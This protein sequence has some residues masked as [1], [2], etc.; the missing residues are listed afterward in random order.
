[1]AAK[2]AQNAMRRDLHQ[3]QPLE[4]L[5]VRRLRYSDGPTTIPWSVFVSLIGIPFQERCWYENPIAFLKN[6]KS[7]VSLIW[8]R[9][10]QK[11]WNSEHGSPRHVHDRGA[12][13]FRCK[14]RFGQR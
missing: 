9:S 6:S 2:R 10:S 11:L 12:H 3:W 13:R 8:L 1:M 4:T 5:K 7:S 14:S